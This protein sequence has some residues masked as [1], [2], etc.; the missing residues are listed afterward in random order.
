MYM[1]TTHSFD[2]NRLAATLKRVT[3]KHEAPMLQ[4]RYFTADEIIYSYDDGFAD[5]H[6][7]IKADVNT[8]FPAF[9]LTKTFTAVAILQLAEKGLLHIDD[10]VQQYLPT[11]PVPPVMST[12]FMLFIDTTNISQ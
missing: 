5:L 12:V 1:S 11:I 6:T 4:Y 3:E 8:S 10:R 7:Q 9:S 2:S